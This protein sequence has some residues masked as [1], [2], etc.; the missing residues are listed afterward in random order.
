MHIKSSPICL[1]NQGKIKA[2]ERWPKNCQESQ[3]LISPRMLNSVVNKA[4][5]RELF[6]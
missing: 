2:N 5:T 1:L 4:I 3:N 6:L